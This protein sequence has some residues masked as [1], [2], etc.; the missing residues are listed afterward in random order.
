[1]EK[2][3]KEKGKEGILKKT[4]DQNVFLKRVAFGDRNKISLEIVQNE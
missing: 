1:M 3:F 4:F 2:G